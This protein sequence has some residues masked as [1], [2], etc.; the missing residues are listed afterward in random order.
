MYNSVVFYS[1]H[2]IEQPILLSHIEYHPQKKP[3]T[4]EGLILQWNTV[5]VMERPGMQEGC[6]WQMASEWGTLYVGEPSFDF[7]SVIGTIT[8]LWF[9][10]P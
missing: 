5:A 10:F 3:W 9:F 7:T 1:I 8:A 2:R 6:D 4:P